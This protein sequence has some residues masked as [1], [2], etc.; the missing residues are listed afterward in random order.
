VSTAQLVSVLLCSMQSIDLN[1]LPV[2]LTLLEEE[3]VTAAAARLN[4]SVPATSRALERARR[5]FGDPLLVRSGRGVVTTPRARELLPEL[6]NALAGLA[7]VLDRPQSFDSRRLRRTF[8]IR[9]NET[10]I[11][12]AG[13]TLITLVARAAPHVEISFELETSDDIA[14]LRNGDADLAI[15]SYGDANSDIETAPL[16]NESLVAVVRAGHPIIKAG[17]RPSLQRFAQLDHIVV[18]R[19]GLSRKTV[20][21]IQTPPTQNR[22]GR[23]TS[24]DAPIKR[25]VIAVVPSFAVALAI[26]SKS[27]ATTVA[28]SHLAS[29]FLD[30]GGL[31]RFTP[32]IPLPTVT[33]SQ[34]WH[35]SKSADPAHRWLRSCVEHAAA[36][37]ARTR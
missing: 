29:L 8:T 16:L 4:L 35:A 20:E 31:V 11:A 18:S 13:A 10:V 24:A 3:S 21:M 2:V 23:K 5:I 28:P 6:T 7:I 22:S 26:I 19:R 15:G 30:H 14:A 17:A 27:D 37:V 25:S 1:L 33:V 36:T 9:A 32:P 34:L 12:A